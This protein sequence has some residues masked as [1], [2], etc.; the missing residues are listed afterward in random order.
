MLVGRVGVMTFMVSVI[1][2]KDS[3]IKYP[4]ENMMVG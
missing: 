4:E 3:L 1:T 2:Q